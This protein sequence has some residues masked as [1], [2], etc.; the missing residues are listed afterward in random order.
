M[1][2]LEDAFLLGRSLF[3]SIAVAPEGAS[4]SRTGVVRYDYAYALLNECNDLLMLKR[5][6]LVSD[7]R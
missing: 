6:M 3:C 7:Y 2:V 5:Q 4:I 1:R